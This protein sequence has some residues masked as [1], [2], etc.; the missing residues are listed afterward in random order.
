MELKAAVLCLTVAFC[1]FL[2]AFD[3][4]KKVFKIFLKTFFF[5]AIIPLLGLFFFLYVLI[6]VLILFFFKIF[7]IINIGN[8]FQYDNLTFANLSV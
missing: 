6:F 2:F 1:Y 7:I 8:F 5:V 4:K 3:Q